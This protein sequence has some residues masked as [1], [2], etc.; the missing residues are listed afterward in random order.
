MTTMMKRTLLAAWGLFA[1]FLLLMLG[2]GLIGVVLGVRAGLEGFSTTTTGVIM[3]SYF[4][5]FVAGSQITPRIMARVGHIRVFSALTSLVAVAA[6][7]HAL[8]VAPLP[9]I[10][11]RLLFGFSM[12]GLFVTAESWLNETVTNDNRGRVMAVYMVVSMGG[13]AGGQFLL[14]AGDPSGTT[15][16]IIAAALVSLAIVPITLSI[17]SAPE[18]KLPPS[19]NPREIWSAAPVGVVGALFAGMGNSALLGMAAVY[20]SQVGMSLARTALFAGAAA[21]GAVVLQWPIGYLSDYIGRRQMILIVSSIAVVV[22]V[23]GVGLTP[24]GWPILIAMFLFGGMSY[25]MYSLALSHVIDVL[26]SGRAVTASSTNV[27]LTGVGAIFGPLVAAGLMTA[28]GPSG[29]WWT[30]VLAFGVI[31]VFAAY[32]LI[33]RPKIEGLSP[34]PYL[35]VPARSAG[36]VRLVRRNGKK[37]SGSTDS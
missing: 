2:R 7:F 34:E 12:A 5:G 9:W 24:V 36:I 10:G 23:V 25:P 33:K 37:P 15:L 11:L 29:F 28:I 21:I 20:A 30:L 8:W 22:A 27:F 32:R 17:T 18:F 31:A 4:V 6:L 19:Q 14:G 13:V 26:P 1:S 35:A 3:A 16:F